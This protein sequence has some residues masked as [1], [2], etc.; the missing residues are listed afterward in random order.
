MGVQLGL[1]QIL[2]IQ[3]LCFWTLSIVLFLFKTTFLFCLHL[4]MEPTQMVPIDRSSPYLWPLDNVQKHNNY[5]NIPLS[6]NFRSWRLRVFENRDLTRI[7]G[8]KREKI[9]GGLR[10]RCNEELCNLY[11]LPS[12]IRM[13]KSRRMIWAG[14]V[15]GMGVKRDKHRVWWGNQ[16]ERGHYE[17]LG[18]D[19]KITLK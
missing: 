11:S 7:F 10:T 16:K 1:S 4:Q 9:I 6:Q 3:L 19:G 8:P 15:W 13:I 2:R 14:L 18:I 5:I 17:D 12:I